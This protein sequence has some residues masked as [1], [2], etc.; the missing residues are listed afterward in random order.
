MKELRDS[1]WNYYQFT[2]DHPDVLVSCHD[3]KDN[4]LSLIDDLSFPLF[5][6]TGYEIKN[7]IELKQYLEA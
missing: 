6:A 3:Y 4:K 5:N 7:E 2:N 1:H